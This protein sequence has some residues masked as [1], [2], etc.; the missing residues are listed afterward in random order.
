M[1][2]PGLLII[3]LVCIGLNLG[4][5]FFETPLL[6]QFAQIGF[7]VP[8]LLFF[9]KELL[10]SGLNFPAFVFLSLVAAIFM[11]IEQVWEN[12]LFA[13]MA[14]MGAYI[15]LCREALMYIKRESASRYM[16]FYF[17]FLLIT[18]GYLML[19]H[20]QD[21]QPYLGTTIEYI[22]YISFY[23]NIIVLGMVALIYYLNSYSRKSVYFI[24]MVLAFLFADL[25]RDMGAYYL[26]DLSVISVGYLLRLV[27]LAFAVMFFVTPEK[28]LRLLHMV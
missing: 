8:L 3:L 25:F 27:G 16:L 23:L 1:N 4:G 22:F 14:L 21:L 17:I 26:N 5:V 11:E 19:D 7:F 20:I 6:V 18:N 15:F 2:L 13:L 9:R 28:K 24:T 10:Y 12:E